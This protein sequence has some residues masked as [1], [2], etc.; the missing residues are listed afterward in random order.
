MARSLR[1]STLAPLVLAFLPFAAGGEPS[2]C[3][4]GLPAF[5]ASH[6]PSIRSTAVARRAIAFA[7]RDNLIDEEIFGTLEQEGVEPAPRSGAPEFLRRVTLDLTGRPPDLETTLAFLA[8]SSPDA[9][10]RRIEA[11]IASEAFVD[12]W[13]GFLSELYRVTAYSSTSFMG[14]SGRNAWHRFFVNELRAGTPYDQIARRVLTASGTGREVGP[15]NFVVRDIAFNGP[16]QDTWDNLAASTGRVLLG[17]NLFCVS[18][19]DGAG[20]VEGLNLWLSGMTRRDFWGLSAFFAQTAAR[21]EYLEREREFRYDIFE[22]PFLEY[23]LDTTDGNKSPR[24]PGPDGAVVVP[25]AFPLTGQAPAFFEA[26]RGALARLVTSNRQFARATVN[27]VWKELFNLGLVEPAGDFDLARLDPANPPPSP[28]TLQPTHPA[29]LE[30]LARHFEE[31]GYDLRALIRLI[32]K[33]EAYQLS[34]SYPAEWKAE[35]VPLFARHLTRR[36]R[37]EELHDAISVATF[38]PIPLYVKGF[39]APVPWASQLPDTYEPLGEDP[40]GVSP[41]VFDFLRTFGRGD[42]DLAARTGQGSLLQ[43]VHLFNNPLLTYR[44]RSDVPGTLVARVIAANVPKEMQRDVLFLATLSRL[45]TEEEGR[46]ALAI[47]KDPLR[48]PSAAL[49]DLHFALLNKLDFLYVY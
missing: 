48:S 21:A 24:T 47:L 34:S 45:P 5:Q 27:Y 28:W 16:P 36:L 38:L 42:R 12:R 43:A 23:R 32:V 14:P 25:P 46:A 15:A 11:L 13:A 1:R 9:R 30:R 49:E 6:A 26:R 4:A 18:C 7:S 8:D 29:L 33:S 17:T 40:A 31:S 19:H 20:H 37:A 41:V 22:F 2:E 10:E 35:Y 3:P 44:V 39:E